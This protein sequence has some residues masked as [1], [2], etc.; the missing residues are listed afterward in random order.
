MVLDEAHE[1]DI[2]GAFGTIRQ[3]DLDTRRSWR[4][5][6]LTLLAIM[7]PGLIVM[8]GDNDA[9]G[10]ATYS[11]AGQNFGL[12]LLWLLP[13]LVP[14]LV[15]NQEM[16]V[17]L[18]A[19]TGVGHARLINERFG[20]F[21]GAFSVGDLFILNFLTI[22]TEFIGVSLALHYFGISEY[23]S[24]P[25]AAVGLVVMTA[26]GSFRRWE[27]FMFVFIAINFLVI[28][29]AF[30]SHPSAG[31]FFKGF[32]TFGVHGGFTSTS[33]LLIIAI[34][35]TTVAPWQ[36]FFQQSNIVDKRITP[37]WINYERADTVV[38]SLITV[39]AAS[40]LMAVVASAFAGTPFFG[41]F[42]NAGGVA[43]G[44]QHT[45][46]RAAG[47]IFAIILLNASVIGAASVTL[48]TSYAF[49]DMFGAHHSLHRSWRDAKFFYG[50][51]T[52][53]VVAA[54][55]IVLIPGAPL[56]LIT[57]SVQALAGV[58]LP[59]ATVFLLMLCNDKEVLGPWVNRP[60]LNVL[61]TVIVSILLVMSLIL[62]ATTL[63]SRIDVTELAAVLGGLLLVLF[64]VGGVLYA[65][66][67]RRHPPEP[68]TPMAKRATWRMPA[69]NLLQR[70]TW[71]RGR[72][73]AM[74]ALRGYLVVAVLMLL[75][76][77]IELG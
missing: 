40:L 62:M 30:L 38:G 32:V 51:F 33:V 72:L 76:K 37:R 53:M 9:G 23:I 77:A 36:L 11:Q 26:S 22:A 13:L 55:G 39:F 60:W 59:S 57:T 74:Y 42:T 46:G 47:A 2:Q 63:F 34:V 48:A 58:L 6:L 65:R 29:L 31:P 24:V 50:A 54:A 8:V 21:W 18:G 20:K 7:G 64:A 71:S 4:A 69:L 12:T 35:G 19:V 14:V 56:G 5:R 67:L 45:V 61:A 52:A 68:V 28:P 27:R 15:V 41:H 66:A 10:V 16:V 70:P 3:H 44:L 1:G 49:G 75:V 73:V 25:I 17:R 43:T